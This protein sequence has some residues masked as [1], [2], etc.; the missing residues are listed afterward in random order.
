VFVPLRHDPGHAQ[1]DFGDALA[2]IAGGRAQDPQP[3]ASSRRCTGRKTASWA[4]AQNRKPII[5]S[6]TPSRRGAELSV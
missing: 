1:V 4:R 2:E 5:S 3:L 6:P